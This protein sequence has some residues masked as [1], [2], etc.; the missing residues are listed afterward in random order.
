MALKKIDLYEEDRKSPDYDP[1]KFIP[2]TIGGINYNGTSISFKEFPLQNLYFTE[3]LVGLCLKEDYKIP[4][5][6]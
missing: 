4:R 3:S 2:G 6:K 5:S 1:E